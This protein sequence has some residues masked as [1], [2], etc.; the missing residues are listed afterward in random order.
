MLTCSDVSNRTCTRNKSY[1]KNNICKLEI[2]LFCKGF[3]E[4]DIVPPMVLMVERSPVVQY[5]FLGSLLAANFCTRSSTGFPVGMYRASVRV[6]TTRT[7]RCKIPRNITTIQWQNKSKMKKRGASKL[8]SKSTISTNTAMLGLLAEMGHKFYLLLE[9][10]CT[11][12]P[13]TIKCCDFIGNR[14]QQFPGAFFCHGCDMWGQRDVS[15]K[16]L[17]GERRVYCHVATHSLYECWRCRDWT[18]ERLN[19]IDRGK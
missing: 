19:N 1:R 8:A 2:D 17:N 11:H 18:T 3:R 16:R 15:N 14:Q 13:T 7:E 4:R 6:G 9:K 10:N 12:A 5:L